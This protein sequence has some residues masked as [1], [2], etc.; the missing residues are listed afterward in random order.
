M[1]ECSQDVQ[2]VGVEAF[3]ADSVSFDVAHVLLDAARPAVVPRPR[4]PLIQSNDSQ[5]STFIRSN[6][7]GREGFDAVPIHLDVPVILRVI[8]AYGACTT[9]GTYMT[10]PGW[11][12][13]PEGSGQ[14]RWWDGR[15]WTSAVQPVPQPQQAPPAPEK[16]PLTPEQKRR[17][18][19]VGGVAAAVV[20]GIVIVGAWNDA[21][22]ADPEIHAAPTTTSAPA[23]TDTTSAAPQRQQIVPRATTTVRPPSPA[24]APPAAEPIFDNEDTFILTLSMSDYD[25]PEPR[26]KLVYSGRFV[27]EQLDDGKDQQTVAT[28]MYLSN[29]S[30]SLEQSGYLMGVAIASFCPEY[31]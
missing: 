25:Y 11:H 8:H 1:L 22:G 20:L 17:N 9:K 27:C 3:G 12:P 14:L 24:P 2:A 18:Y 21:E 19:I 15:Q 10:Q 31:R 26:A 6:E 28:A 13:D 16:T 4:A 7:R 29:D 23:T 30:W 5:R